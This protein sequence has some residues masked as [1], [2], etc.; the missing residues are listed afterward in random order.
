MCRAAIG[1]ALTEI[2]FTDHL[3]VHPLD[4]CP[5]YYEPDTY[6]A[7]LARCR[8]LFAGELTI[9][10]GIEVGD[11]HRFGAE[12]ARTVD[13][14]PY[15]F[16]LG[17]VHWIGDEAPFGAP[18]YESHDSDWTYH[19]YFREALALAGADSFD[20]LGHLDMPKREGTAYFGRFDPNLYGDEI[21]AILRR[22]IDRGKGIEI[23]TSGWRRSADEC[24]PGPVVL[25]WYREM[26]GEILT[27]G[28][29]GHRPEQL[30]LRFESAYDVARAAGFRWLT[31]FDRRKPV[32][33]RL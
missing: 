16:S 28:S 12:I 2:V 31:T 13:A 32:Q 8:D 26:G 29:D 20:V 11:T 27:I 14:F 7:E 21:R 5:G 17:S 15:D 3:D 33:H 22:L 9:K 18:F 30:A 23:N 4:D 25:Q 19:G 10:A 6:F 24:C 1:H